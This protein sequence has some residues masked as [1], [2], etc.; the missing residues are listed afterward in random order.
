MPFDITSASCLV[1]HFV[2]TRQWLRT[3]HIDLHALA[4]P[5]MAW[6][7]PMVAS[8]ESLIPVSRQFQAT[9]IGHFLEVMTSGRSAI[10]FGSPLRG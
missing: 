9:T 1:K 7:L 5:S 10:V 8:D 2:C 3:L 6:A 4:S